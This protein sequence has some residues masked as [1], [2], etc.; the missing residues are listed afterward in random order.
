MYQVKQGQEEAK[1]FYQGKT[2][3]AASFSNEE[4]KAIAEN[5]PAFVAEY[6]E[7]TKAKMVKE[8]SE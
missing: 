8:K 5:D 2:R 3:T 4:V 6:W 7:E 1:F